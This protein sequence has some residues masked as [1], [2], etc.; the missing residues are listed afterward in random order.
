MSDSL[1]A[2]TRV[3]VTGAGPGG[4]AA[5]VLLARSGAQVIL[6]ERVA[7]SAPVGAGLLLQPNGIAVLNALGLGPALADAG[8]RIDAMRL[9][10]GDGRA[11][12]EVP[13]PDHGHG[14]DHL[15]AIRRSSLDAMLLAAVD[16]EPTIATM[17]GAEVVGLGDGAQVVVAT[18]GERRTISA[19][20][21][22][23]ADGA[24]S[25]VR[26]HGDFGARRAASGL[27]YARALVPSPVGLEAAEHWSELGLFGHTPIGDGTAYWYADVTHPAVADSLAAGDIDRFRAL[28]RNAT[29]AAG[30]LVDGLAGLGDLLVNDVATVR[31]RR[32]VDG[33]RVLI[34]DAAHAMA[35]T[36][37]QGANS[38]LVDAAV[39]ALE[40]GAATTLFDGL[41]AYEQRRRAPVQKVARDSSRVAGMSRGGS[42]LRRK[43]RD[44]VV[45]R[46]AGSPSSGPRHA[47]AAMQE[48]PGA[49]YTDLLAGIPASQPGGSSDHAARELPRAP[50]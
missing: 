23:G 25:A 1:L 48:Q 34:G 10:G 47:A 31:C 21:V 18:E 41:R 35:P 6:L 50:K 12:S 29:P 43:L 36:L 17:R 27:R 24:R 9:V 40:L 15:L 33:P 19:D 26:S 13:V 30:D 4:A 39:L 46:A 5:A 14:L 16:A 44:A 3:I 38:A 45:R 49:L 22:V 20:L 32:F 42:K 7:L 8:H 28:W 37:G 2:R 11:L